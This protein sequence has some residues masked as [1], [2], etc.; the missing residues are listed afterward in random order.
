MFDGFNTAIFI[1][2]AITVPA[3]FLVAYLSG[4]RE[5]HYPRRRKPFSFRL[6]LALGLALWNA[7][8]I[9]ED[10]RWWTF[11]PVRQVQGSSTVADIKAHG[12]SDH[13][14]ATTDAHEGTHEVNALIRNRTPNPR[15]NAFYCLDDRCI[16][17]AEPRVTMAQIADQVP[18][19]MRGDQFDLYMVHARGAWNYQPLF[20]ID[21]WVGYTHGAIAGQETGHNQA[22]HQLR[23]ANEISWYVMTLLHVVEER[24]PRYPDREQLAAFIAW[25]MERIERLGGGL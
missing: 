7:P 23:V 20:I 13:G 12:G 11:R 19:A 4:R 1:V 16:V 5:L 3:V 10:L 21:E 15:D 18:L 9:G 22:R 25:N 6:W 8:A 24:D 14:G 2:A 17:L